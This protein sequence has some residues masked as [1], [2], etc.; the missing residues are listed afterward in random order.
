M[1]KE[2]KDM[3]RVDYV[4][5]EKIKSVSV[6]LSKRNPWFFHSP[7]RPLIK[8]FLG[9]VKQSYHEGGYYCNY[10]E[11]SYKTEEEAVRSSEVDL[12]YRPNE[13]EG[14]RIWYKAKVYIVTGEKDGTHMVYF[15]EDRD[16]LD[17]ADDIATRFEH[18]K[19]VHNY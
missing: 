11:R 10:N 12:V 13:P 5:S 19:M 16:A 15:D 6:T 3:K 4:N 1:K 7:E 9:I 14:E 8:G 18:I 2:N 17:Y